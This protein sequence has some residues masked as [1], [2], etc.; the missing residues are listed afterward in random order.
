MIVAVLMLLAATPSRD[1]STSLR[2][3]AGVTGA[4]GAAGRNGREGLRSN[5]LSRSCT[6]PNVLRGIQNNTPVCLPPGPGITSTTR[7]YWAGVADFAAKTSLDAG[8]FPWSQLQDRMSR[9]DANQ[10]QRMI[11]NLHLPEGA[12]IQNVRCWTSDAVAGS[13]DAQ[14]IHM[15]WSVQGT[16]CNGIAASCGCTNTVTSADDPVIHSVTLP[17]YVGPSPPP[18][19]GCV[20]PVSTT[21]VNGPGSYNAHSIEVWT[22]S[23]SASLV[24]FGC[25]VAYNVTKALP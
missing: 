5:A 25:D 10:A 7:Y 6:A 8:T 14:S 16:T 24:F 22:T 1:A 13:T 9:R 3:P 23:T 17:L 15:A 12:T 4:P 2:G 21:L 19:A 20:A 11:A 18:D